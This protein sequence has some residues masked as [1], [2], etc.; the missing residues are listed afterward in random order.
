MEPTPPLKIK[1]P[2]LYGAVEKHHIQISRILFRQV[3]TVLKKCNFL[4]IMVEKGPLE[5]SLD[6]LQY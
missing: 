4:V 6:Y 2:E 1:F 3:K 5:T